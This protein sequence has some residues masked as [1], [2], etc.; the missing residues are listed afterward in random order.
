MPKR[1]LIAITFFILIFGNY[2][3]ADIQTVNKLIEDK[4][5]DEAK[6][7]HVSTQKRKIKARKTL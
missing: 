5:F 4:K 6:I 2:S 3:F 7:I 1:F